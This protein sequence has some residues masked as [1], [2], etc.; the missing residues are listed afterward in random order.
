MA[1]EAVVEQLHNV[2]DRLSKRLEEDDGDKKM[3]PFMQGKDKK[4]EKKDE[5]K[6]SMAY[7]DDG[8]AK[9]EFADAISLDYLNWM[10]DTLKSAGIDVANARHH[11]DA[12]EKGYSPGEDG[13]SHRGQPPLGIVGE[14]T[15][16]PKANFG[17]GG[18]GN[19]FAIRAS[20]DP[21]NP[22]Q[23][24]Q[25]VLKENVSASQLEEAYEVF[26]SAALEQNFKE[27][28]NQVF[29]ERLQGE[30]MAKAQYEAAHSYDARAPVDRLEK[31]LLELASRVDSINTG[32]AVGGEIRKSAPA[33]EIPST[34]SLATMDWAEVH[35][36]ASKALRGGE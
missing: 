5:K 24:N 7:S 28:L 32:G 36:L 6:D 4:D 8:Y 12:V 31:A 35:N 33:L 16:S 25:F 26:K 13:A 18:R 30:L 27:E 29:S 1:E 34:E 22:P 3:P 14:G 19:K 9:G 15:T 17:S 11:F 21:W 23:G 20:Q 10:E 2:L